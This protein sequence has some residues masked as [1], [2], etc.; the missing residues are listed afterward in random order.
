MVD[1]ELNALPERYRQPLVLRYLAGK[2]PSEIATELSMT[3]GAVEGLLK[4]GKH[5][6]RNRL[7]QRGITTLGTALVAIQLTQQTVQAAGNELLIDS[8]IQASLAWG[9]QP[10]IPTPD[11]ISDRVLELAGKEII[12]MTTATKTA[13]AVGLTLGGL[14]MGLGGVNA[15]FR[16]PG[17]KAEAGNLVT[18]ISSSRPA[19][20]TLDLASLAND[21]DE[22]SVTIETTDIDLADNHDGREE[23]QPKNELAQAGSGFGIVDSDSHPKS[24]SRT[25]WDFKS[26]SPR[27]EKIEMALQENAEVNF[28]DLGLRDAVDVLEDIHKIEIWI[29]KEALKE[30]DISIDQN[31]N[32]VMS[33]IPLK[34]A[35]RLMFDP[36]KLDYLIQDDVLKITSRSK[37]DE[38]FETRVYNTGLLPEYTPK[39]LTELILTTVDPEGWNLPM[40]VRS[41][42]PANQTPPTTEAPAS[43][44]WPADDHEASTKEVAEGNSTP[45]LVGGPS[46]G[47]AT[48]TGGMVAGRLSGGIFGNSELGVIRVTPKSLVIRQRQRIHD[49]IIELLEQLK[50]QGTEPAEKKRL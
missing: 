33:G 44:N 31:L 47:G 37:A 6:L 20:N 1:V 50:G 49:E 34:N 14:A 45:P 36:L 46:V 21:A 29:D 17:G 3:V 40:S 39:E 27:V 11:L 23:R 10:N 28:T 18:T 15:L 19:R 22:S 32:L 13:V 12:T 25:K 16:L 7:L 4:R 5:E 2:S 41:L 8:T 24:G 48:G 38:T 26:R 42:V 30:S 9:S 43:K 35:L